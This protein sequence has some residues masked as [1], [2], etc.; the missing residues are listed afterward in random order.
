MINLPAVD[1]F[2]ETIILEMGDVGLRWFTEDALIRPGT[3][4]LVKGRPH[5]DSA[6]KEYP[7][8]QTG[9]LIDS[10]D[11][12]HIGHLM[13]AI[14]SF[15]DKNQEGYAHAVKLESLPESKGGRHFFEKALAEGELAHVMLSRH[16]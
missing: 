7:A 13:V 16:V 12:R 5:Q 14:G 8:E 9:A 6:Q 2:L 4:L 3:G 1:S 15:S 11:V 10:F